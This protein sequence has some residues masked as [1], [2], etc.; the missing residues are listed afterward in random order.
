MKVE[1]SRLNRQKHTET[2]VLLVLTE[3][4]VTLKEY[5]A[6][7]CSCL[8]SLKSIFKKSAPMR[9]AAV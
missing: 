4:V 8:L 1:R 5:A 2:L 6:V 7:L 9:C 3:Q